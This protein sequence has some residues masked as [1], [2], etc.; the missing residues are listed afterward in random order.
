ML[1]GALVLGERLSGTSW[2]ALGVIA[3]GV[4]TFGWASVRSLKFIDRSGA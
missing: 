2:L 4:L 3:F 1:L